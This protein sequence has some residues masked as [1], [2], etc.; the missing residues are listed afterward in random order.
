MNLDSR[1]TARN[2]FFLNLAQ[3]LNNL[4]SFLIS[5]VNAMAMK[6][7]AIK[8]NNTAATNNKIYLNTKYCRKQA[9]RY[10]IGLFVSNGNLRGKTTHF[11]QFME[12]Q[13]KNYFISLLF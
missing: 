6:K 5:L 4:K 13:E 11:L 8:V 2:R 3:S 1:F 9:I 10:P 7:I 12:F